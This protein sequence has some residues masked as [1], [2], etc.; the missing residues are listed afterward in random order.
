MTGTV[1]TIARLGVI[2]AGQFEPCVHRGFVRDR[3]MRGPHASRCAGK[4]D[5]ERSKLERLEGAPVIV[6]EAARDDVGPGERELKECGGWQRVDLALVD[7][8]AHILRAARTRDGVSDPG[9]VPQMPAARE[10]LAP[11]WGPIQ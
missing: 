7:K 3:L 2:A 11:L 5:R 8:S 4:R 9:H 10:N 1:S 6:L